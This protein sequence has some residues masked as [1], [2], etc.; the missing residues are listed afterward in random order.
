MQN[1]L[2]P[3]HPHINTLT[4]YTHNHIHNAYQY[5]QTHAQI[6]VSDPEN[7]QLW[8]PQLQQVKN[9]NIQG[10]LD[11]AVGMTSSLNDPDSDQEK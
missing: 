4:P 3:P 10:F 9:L 6:I 8:P 1:D 11:R 7:K 2:L 5:I